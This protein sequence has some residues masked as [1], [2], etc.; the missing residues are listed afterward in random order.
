MSTNTAN[1]LKTPQARIAKLQFCHDADC[2]LVP[3]LHLLIEVNEVALSQDVGVAISYTWGE[4]NRTK[5]A[6][7]HDQNSNVMS[8]ELGAEWDL[9]DFIVSLE[10]LSRQYQGCWIDQLCIP[11]QE[12]QIIATLASIPT[13]YRTLDVVALMPGSVCACYDEIVKKRALYS[14]TELTTRGQVR[15]QWMTD[16]YSLSSQCVSAFGIHSY[17]DRVWTRQ[18]LMYSRRFKVAWTNNQISACVKS[19]KDAPLLGTFAQLSF[20]QIVAEGRPPEGAMQLLR[21]EAAFF[22]SKG[23]TAVAEYANLEDATGYNGPEALAIWVDVV[24]GQMIESRVPHPEACS[25]QENLTRFLYQMG[26]LG[27]S[28]RKA[29]Q[30]RDYV[31]SV[32]VDC[33]GYRVPENLS[34]RDPA[35]LLQDALTQMMDNHQVTIA[36]TA[37]G[38]LF[39]NSAAGPLWSTAESFQGGVVKNAG[40]IY[41][42]LVSPFTPVPVD[43]ARQLPLQLLPG[44]SLPVSSRA[45]DYEQAVRGRPIVAIFELLKTVV[46]HW[47]FLSIERVVQKNLAS[48]ALATALQALEPNGFNLELLFY[49]GI[50][51]SAMSKFGQP[52]KERSWGGM[53]MVDHHKVAYSLVADALGLTVEGCKRNH[54]KLVLSEEVPPCI[55]L[56]K[57]GMN[58]SL[59]HLTSQQRLKLN[60]GKMLTVCLQ[61]GYRSAGCHLIEAQRVGESN[62]YETVGIWV[63]TGCTPFHDIGA[64]VGSEAQH[65]FLV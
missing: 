4:F 24:G 10:D 3:D 18:E 26:R 36:S 8:L 51:D 35:E 14:A 62:K 57:A 7:G 60:D 37:P 22:F 39:G 40:H 50:T 23:L 38:S 43:K 11:Q 33:P 46:G 64:I 63:P 30:P 53:P 42:S 21:T 59:A 2:Q 34:S 31:L 12:K 45:V 48:V 1:P 20:Q 49:G 16:I 6:I 5:T 19:V 27:L 52:G 9:Q 55:G 58:A 56:I 13:I 65:A 61:R 54:L 17:F 41:G 25:V 28:S 44:F 15:Q 47:P 32:W 29:T